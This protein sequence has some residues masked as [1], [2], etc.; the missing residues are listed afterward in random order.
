MKWLFFVILLSTMVV[1]QSVS[2]YPYFLFYGRDFNAYIIKG[3]VRE[4]SEIVASNLVI[5]MLPSLYNPLFRIQDGFNFW[6]IRADAASV[7]ESVRL[8]SE[9]LVLDRPAVVVGTP[10]NN[11]WIQRILELDNC[12]AFAPDMGVVFVKYYNGFPVVVITGGSGKSVFEAAKWL[13]SQAHFRFH[14]EGVVIKP[15]VGNVMIGDGDLLAIGEPIGHVTPS[16]SVGQN[17][18]LRFGPGRVVFGKG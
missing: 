5:N 13:H 2:D 7:I 16:I 17:S 10:C 14:S 15:G 11:V 4:S 1:A 3:D 9:V 8:A 6:R 12:N 18:Y